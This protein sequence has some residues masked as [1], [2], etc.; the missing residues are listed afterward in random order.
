MNDIVPFVVPAQIERDVTRQADKGH[1][2]NRSI[3]DLQLFLKILSFHRT[4]IL[5]DQGLVFGISWQDNAEGAEKIHHELRAVPTP[6]PVSPTV[7]LVKHFEGLARHILLGVG[8]KSIMDIRR[9]RNVTLSERPTS[10]LVT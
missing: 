6:Q 3:K 1:Q 2:G 4:Q 5:S 7:R 8:Q 10:V 9:L